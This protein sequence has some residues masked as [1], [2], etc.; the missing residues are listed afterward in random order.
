MERE[1]LEGLRVLYVGS[2]FLFY[3]WAFQNEIHDELVI[4]TDTWRCEEVL[5][6][7]CDTLIKRDDDY[8]AL[9]D[10]IVKESDGEPCALGIGSKTAVTKRQLAAQLVSDMEHLDKPVIFKTSGPPEDF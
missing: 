10:F 6:S 1:N 5:Q 2:K 9:L 7:I 8:Y 3:L 4:K